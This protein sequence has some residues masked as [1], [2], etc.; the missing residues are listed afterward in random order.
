MSQELGGDSD[1]LSEMQISGD[2]SVS[3]QFNWL[4]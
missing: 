3:K 1:E 4:Y 2:S